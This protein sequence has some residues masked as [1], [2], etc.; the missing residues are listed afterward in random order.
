MAISI[1]IHSIPITT[2]NIPDILPHQEKLPQ[3]IAYLQTLQIPFSASRQLLTYARLSDS[4]RNLN[5]I[6]NVPFCKASTTQSWDMEF[7]R[8]VAFLKCILILQAPPSDIS[9]KSKSSTYWNKNSSS[10]A[11][12]CLVCDLGEGVKFSELIVRINGDEGIFFD[13]GVLGDEIACS[14][15]I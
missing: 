15:L 5:Y 10:S 8:A 9:A 2:A 3:D 4:Q 1:C 11:R 7:S 12:M 14:F 13:K 6:R